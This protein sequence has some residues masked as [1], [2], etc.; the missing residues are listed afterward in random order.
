MRLQDFGEDNLGASNAE[1]VEKLFCGVCG[2]EI[3]ANPTLKNGVP[4]RHTEASD[5]PITPCSFAGGGIYSLRTPGLLV[6]LY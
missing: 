6:K 3:S 2:V 4:L 1:W 5:R